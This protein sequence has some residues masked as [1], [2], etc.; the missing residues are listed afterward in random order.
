VPRTVVVVSRRRGGSKASWLRI[1]TQLASRYRPLPDTGER[2]GQDHVK[3][4]FPTSVDIWDA[5]VKVAGW[6]DEIDDDWRAN[7]VMTLGGEPPPGGIPDP[8]RPPKLRGRNL[9]N[10]REVLLALRGR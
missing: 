2:L 8:L 7:I 9:P 6:L 3:F 1:T 4:A 10:W 5:R